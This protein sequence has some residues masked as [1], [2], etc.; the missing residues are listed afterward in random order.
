MTN[1]EKYL[2]IINQ[3]PLLVQAYT[4]QYSRRPTH[5]VL[6]EKIYE[7]LLAEHKLL[8]VPAEKDET[9]NTILGAIVIPSPY[10]EYAM[11]WHE[12]YDGFPMTLPD[13]D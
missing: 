11:V 8:V 5:C 10:V 2:S 3:L 9:P 12:L 13:K 7:F 6:P 1:N 4:K